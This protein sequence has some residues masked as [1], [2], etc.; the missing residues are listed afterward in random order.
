MVVPGSLEYENR[1]PRDFEV[2]D[3]NISWG[4][5]MKSRRQWQLILWGSVASVLGGATSIAQT[6]QERAIRP[7]RERIIEGWLIAGSSN[8]EGR[9]KVA[10]QQVDSGGWPSFVDDRAKDVYDW[11]IRRFWLHNP[12]GTLS[13][14]DMQFDQYLDAQ[15]AGLDVLTENFSEAWGPVVRG[16]FGEPVELI[17]YIGTADPE[18]NRLKATFESEDSARILGMMLAS[19][20]PILLAGA[21]LGADAAVKQSED[22]PA[23]HFYKYLESIGVRT[24]VESRPRQ[25]NP[26]WSEFPVFAVDSWWKRSDPE[27]HEDSAA[28]GALPNSEMQREVVRWFSGYPG[29]STDPVVLK[30]L[31]ARTRTALLKGDTVVL[32]TDGLRAAGVPFETLFEGIDEQLGVESESSTE[33]SSRSGIAGTSVSASI[34]KKRSADRRSNAEGGVPKT[35]KPSSTTKSARSTEGVQI[36]PTSSSPVRGVQKTKSKAGSVVKPKAK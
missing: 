27:I 4:T 6:T 3:R 28:W 19:V 1:E 18:D 9:R 34:R 22:G 35:T 36:K 24:Y 23:F 16:S 25:A 30:A 12:F 14:E 5:L 10:V 21:S 11:G 13:G 2:I 7:A 20:K 17:A 32:S 8:D 31:I 26:K 33:S 15:E 29:K